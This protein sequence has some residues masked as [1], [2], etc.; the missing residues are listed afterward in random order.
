MR[1]GPLAFR[2]L[3]IIGCLATV[4]SCGFEGANNP[5]VGDGGVDGSGPPTIGFLYDSSLEDEESGTINVAVT[6]SHASSAP[7]TIPF[8]ITGGTATKDT[9]YT[10]SNGTL[11]FAP[12]DLQQAIQLVI[13]SDGAEEPNETID[14][15]LGSPS[16]GAILAQSSHTVTI[17]SD[18]LPR[19]NF[20][21][22]TSTALE[23][24]GAQQLNVL[25]DRPPA[26]G[27]SLNYTVSGTASRPSDHGLANGTITF[28]IGSTSQAITLPVI[29]DTMDEFDET[30]IVTLHTPNNVVLGTMSSRTHTILD[31]DLEPGVQFL[32]A[33]AA[34]NETDQ[35]YTVT[36]R[37]TQISGKPITVPFTA[38][39]TASAADYTLSATS[40]Q[41]PAGQ[42]QR[43]VTITVIDDITD[44]DNETV[45]L[46]IGTPTNAIATGQ[47]TYTRAINDEDA[48][49]VVQFDPA[50]ANGAGSEGSATIRY[51]YR[52]VLTP[53]SGKQVTANIDFS[54]S[55]A[56]N[57]SDYTV[58]N[59]DVPVVFN[60]GEIEKIVRINITNDQVNEGGNDEDV[61]MVLSS[62]PTNATRGAVTTRIHSI[63]DDD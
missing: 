50:E 52:V 56:S 44:E 3:L 33:N 9:D 53:A 1:G 7:I 15:A 63:S 24:T 45:V 6:L 61:I 34:D 48:P 49:A 30:V 37:L 55:D 22:T 62:A 40:V 29:E 31:N 41:I 23:N 57:P 19:V 8:T 35:T 51:D 32:T 4:A 28:A 39:G 36:V 13:T 2:Q 16:G 58:R 46:T 60:P 25:L 21:L 59:G 27:V 17:S 54:T 43:D 18:I 5:D 14:L 26:V 11:T 47:T 38:S 42:Q 10:G 12:G 20:T